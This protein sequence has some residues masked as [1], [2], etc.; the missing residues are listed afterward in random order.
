MD[1]HQFTP[2]ALSMIDRFLAFWPAISRPF[3]KKNILKAVHGCLDAPQQ[4]KV[5]QDNVLE[6]IRG[7][8]P[9]FETLILSLKDP[10]KIAETMQALEKGDP[11][12]PLIKISRWDLPPIALQRDV[13]NV[14]ALL[15][16]PRTGGN[17]D[18]ILDAALEGVT[19]SGCTVEKLCFTNLNI[20]PCI[21]CLKCQ[22]EKPDTFCAIR[23]DMIHLYKGLLESDAFILGFP[24]YGGR[25]SAQTAIFFDRLKALSNPADQ[26]KFTPKKGLLVATWGWPSESLYESVVHN[27]A[28]LMRHFGVEVAEVVSGSGFW[29]AYYKRGTALLDQEG[30]AAAK[31]AGSALVSQPTS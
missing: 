25:E 16:S 13:K 28:F 2:E 20:R 8:Y 23:D 14:C 6:A 4:A 12:H 31:A 24:I 9:I 19:E 26:K 21:G 27:I 17:T 11:D 22:D 1:E 3:H 30:I 5:S 18:A 10:G 29:G 7:H 15:A